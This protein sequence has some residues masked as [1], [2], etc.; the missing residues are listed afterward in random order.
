MEL[1]SLQNEMKRLLHTGHLGIVKTISCAQEII[2]WPGIN[3][4]ITNIVN[5]LKYV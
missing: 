5:A 1:F 3:N 4:D 2:D